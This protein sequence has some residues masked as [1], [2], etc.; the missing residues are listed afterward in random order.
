MTNMII[1]D[2]AADK[3]SI[4]TKTSQAPASGRKRAPA[5]ITVL[6]LQPFS[7]AKVRLRSSSFRF[8]SSLTTAALATHAVDPDLN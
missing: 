1:A 4:K 8:A 7:A 6:L 2:A 3:T 5:L